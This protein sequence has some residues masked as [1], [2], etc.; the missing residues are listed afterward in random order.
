MRK[1]YIVSI[2]A[3]DIILGAFSDMRECLEFIKS[4]LNGGVN[5]D[6]LWVTV[7]PDGQKHDEQR[8]YLAVDFLLSGGR[9]R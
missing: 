1:I 8:D 6:L 9:G 2:P 5:P 4:D 3:E 7:C